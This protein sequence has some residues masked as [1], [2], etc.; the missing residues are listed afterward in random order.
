[1]DNTGIRKLPNSNTVCLARIKPEF[2][3]SH[4]DSN[5]LEAPEQ[6]YHFLND[7]PEERETKDWLIVV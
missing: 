1:M 3:C 7:F 6:T 4:S 2:I 5:H